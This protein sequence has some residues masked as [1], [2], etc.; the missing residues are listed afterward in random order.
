[1]ANQFVKLLQSGL[2]FVEGQ[3]SAPLN[4]IQLRAWSRRR[5]L[6]AL[7]LG[8]ALLRR[9]ITGRSVGTVMYLD[10]PWHAPGIEGWMSMIGS[11]MP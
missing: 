3:H 8:R 2:A 1:M 7:G 11:D 9:L 4:A 10:A 6:D 5:I